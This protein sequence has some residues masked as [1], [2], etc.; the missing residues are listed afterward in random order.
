MVFLCFLLLTLVSSGAL[1]QTGVVEDVAIGDLDLFVMDDGSCNAGPSGIYASGQT[2]TIRG[3]GFESYGAVKV[4]VQV[5][6]Q[7]YT[8]KYSL[9]ETQADEAGNLSIAVELPFSPARKAIGLVRATGV[10]RRGVLL[11]LKGMLALAPSATADHDG[12]GVPDI[13]DNC[14]LISNPGQEDSDQDG[15][16]DGCDVFPDDDED[17]FD[18]DGLARNADPCPFNQENDGDG[19]GY[20][21]IIDNCPDISNGDQL[22][23][24]GDGVGDACDERVDEAPIAVDDEAV[25]DSNA[26][27]T[28]LVLDNDTDANGDSLTIAGASDGQNGRVTTNAISVTY[29]PD[30]DFEGADRFIYTVDDGFGGTAPAIVMVTVNASNASPFAE[31]DTG[32]T[33]EDVA[34][35]IPVLANDSDVD[36]DALSV[37]GVSGASNGTVTTDGGSVTFTPAPNFNGTDSF[38]YTI[39]D[40]NGGSATATVTVTLNPANDE[41]LMGDLNGD[42]DIDSWDDAGFRAALRKGEGDTG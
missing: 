5:R 31:D 17:D 19:D 9:D 13:C 39:E 24:D 26:P 8:E 42:G 11:V 16:G 4:F 32:N 36:G 34:V 28:V 1:A 40:G 20:C 12:D 7:D 6:F 10:A 23:A 14:Q 27:V 22:D 25:T 35:T 21:E 3:S 15:L 37:S 29:T 30:L 38:S 18:G 41:R 2:L 33:D